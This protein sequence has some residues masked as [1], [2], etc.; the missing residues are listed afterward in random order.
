MAQLGHAITKR[1]ASSWFACQC[2]LQQNFCYATPLQCTTGGTNLQEQQNDVED[3][4]VVAQCDG[5][6]TLQ[7]Q[8][9][10]GLLR[11]QAEGQ[12]GVPSRR[13]AGRPD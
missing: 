5:D 10:V 2:V 4:H 1:Q 11:S 12:D 3:S 7:H 8:R 13:E 9:E 6:A